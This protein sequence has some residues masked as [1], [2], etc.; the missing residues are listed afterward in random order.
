MLIRL[1]D[2]LLILIHAL[3]EF[4]FKLTIFGLQGELLHIGKDNVDVHV[5][6]TAPFSLIQLL[7]DQSCVPLPSVRA[8]ISGVSDRV[9]I[10]MMVSM[11]RF[12]VLQGDLACIVVI[13]VS[14]AVVYFENVHGLG[15]LIL[16]LEVRRCELCLLRPAIH[17][18]RL[19]SAMVRRRS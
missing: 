7:G 9:L 17:T 12:T 16:N 19:V 5:V 13:L 10:L 11:R 14:I 4:R 3:L 8:I 18:L 2:V 1:L 15:S 6:I